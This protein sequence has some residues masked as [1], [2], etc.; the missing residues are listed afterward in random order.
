MILRRLRTQAGLTGKEVADR[1]GL[2]QTT[3]SRFETGRRVPTENVLRELC[4]IY[5][6]STETRRELLAIATDLR[7]GSTSTRA[8]LH[9]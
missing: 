9:R 1:S 5:G 7:E 3:V 4:R 8:V 6:A 2:S